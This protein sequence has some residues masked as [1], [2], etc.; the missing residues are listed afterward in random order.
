MERQYNNELT[1]E[2]R[3]R[4]HQS[5]FTA[6]ELAERDPAVAGCLTR[7]GGRDDEIINTPRGSRIMIVREGAMLPD[8][9]LVIPGV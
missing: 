3:A 1:P 8:D 5:S 9:F 2:R 6:D 7:N 4:L